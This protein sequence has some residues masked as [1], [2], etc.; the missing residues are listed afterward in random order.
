MKQQ[1]QN[2]LERLK[3]EH[4]IKLNELEK[5]YPVSIENIKDQLK[6]EYYWIDL[7]FQSAAD[8]CSMLNIEFSTYNLSE[9]FNVSQVI[10]EDVDEFEIDRSDYAYELENDK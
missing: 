10:K 6:K 3:P 5:S 4:R 8:L 1:P 7:R 2:L 9:L